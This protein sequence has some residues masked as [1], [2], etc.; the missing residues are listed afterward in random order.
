MSFVTKVRNPTSQA[1][2]LDEWL[3]RTIGN[4]VLIPAEAQ[5]S[6]D[7]QPVILVNEEGEHQVPTEALMSNM[8]QY[9]GMGLNMPDQRSMAYIPQP[10]STEVS[11][12][13]GASRKGPTSSSKIL[14]DDAFPL[15]RVRTAKC[16]TCSRKKPTSS[17]SYGKLL[18]L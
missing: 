10:S 16:S 13:L 17:F 15:K 6:A 8:P 3:H 9:G 18:H 7:S 11:G 5:Q 14:P 2:I 12:I 4:Q 1:I